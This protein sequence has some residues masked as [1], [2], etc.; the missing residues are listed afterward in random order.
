M[1]IIEKR[2]AVRDARRHHQA[3]AQATLD[4]LCFVSTADPTGWI[5]RFFAE[6][7]VFC[8]RPFGHM[9]GI[10]VAVGSD[11]TVLHVWEDAG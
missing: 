7:E 10:H 11:G 8:S 6:R 4:A 3:T 1:N 2:S 5:S 9:D